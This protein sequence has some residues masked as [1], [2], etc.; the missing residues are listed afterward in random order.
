M[1]YKGIRC[2]RH[3][4]QQSID[5][6]GLPGIAKSLVPRLTIDND[7]KIELPK[8]V[9]CS[10]AG[11]TRT[12][13]DEEKKKK[14]IGAADIPIVRLNPFNILDRKRESEALLRQTMSITDSNSKVKYCTTRKKTHGV[15][16]VH[17]YYIGYV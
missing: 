10:S 17:V 6:I 12:I 9:M 8:M 11:V 14:Y 5:L 4:L 3:S 7:P 15:V 1:H 16:T 13:W 2:R